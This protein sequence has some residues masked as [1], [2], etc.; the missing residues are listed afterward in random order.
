MDKNEFLKEQLDLIKRK[1]KDPSIEWQDITDFRNEYFKYPEHRD[2]IRKGSKLLL[3]YIQA[4]WDLGPSSSILNSNEDLLELK[5]E[6]IKIQTEKLELNKWLRELSRD[7]LIAEK[8][9]DAIHGLH[10]VD[11][12]DPIIPINMKKEYLLTLSD[13]HYGVE[14]CIKDLYGYIMNEYSPRIFENR[15]WDLFYQI[16][17]QIKTDHI[18][19]LNIFDL[20]DDLDGLLRANS[21][22]MQLKYGVIDSS[23]LYAN[24][25]SEWLNELSHYVKI[26]FQM[27]KRSNHNQL[28]LV[29]QPKN[30]FPDEDMSNANFLSEWLNELSHYVKIK[31]QM[32]KRSNH[33]QLRLVGQPKNAFP[34]EDMSKSML[35]FIKER[36]KDNPN[37]TIIENPTGLAYAQL[38]TYTILGGHFETKNLADELKNYSKTYGVPI[39]YIF[40]GHWHS[41]FSGD[42]G[43]DSE[44]ISVRSLMGINPYSMQINKTA[45][46]GASMFVFEQGKGITCEYRYKL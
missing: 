25:L 4:G 39:D 36:L 41:S 46:A 14:F 19:V 44:Y 8:I 23:I 3:E 17:E 30:A 20:G 26:K 16:T 45:P 1:Q 12:P 29:G 21:Q 31:F 27:V 35:V 33:N 32:V 24:F 13:A 38:G 15:M 5:K 43:I 9:V 10:P 6:R 28:R 7:E 42:I 34:D 37:I 18:K 22:L 40:S 11:I 2:T